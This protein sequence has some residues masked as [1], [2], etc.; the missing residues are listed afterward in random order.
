ME[1]TIEQINQ[2]KIDKLDI[3]ENNAAI[4]EEESLFYDFD[5]AIEEKGEKP[6]KIKFNKINFLVPSQMPFDF[7]MFF[8]RNCM[9]KVDGKQ[10]FNVNEDD[11]V[12]FITLM[13]G[14]EFLESLEKSRISIKM[15]FEDLALKILN[16]WGYAI[17]AK[18][19]S[20]NVQKKI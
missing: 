8:F 19:K 17:D 1:K 11:I 12:Q 4:E 14:N 7:S 15:I 13:F 18:V 5:K 9:V 16:K 2:E 10:I 3:A 20:E 6:L